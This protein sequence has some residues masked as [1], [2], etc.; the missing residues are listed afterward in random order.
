MVD[1]LEI[2]TMQSFKNQYLAFF[3]RNF[4]EDIFQV[5]TFYTPFQPTFISSFVT[6]QI[7]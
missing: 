7:F 5:C 4:N 1:D 6:F 3:H 2:S